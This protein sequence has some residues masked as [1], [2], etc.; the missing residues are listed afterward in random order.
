MAHNGDTSGKV[1]CEFFAGMGLVREAL[2]REGWRVAYANDIDPLKARLYEAMTGETLDQRDIHDVQVGDLPRA[3]LWTASFPCTDLSLA[4]KG[5]GI[6]GGQSGAVWRIFQLL[7]ETPEGERPR[8]LLFENVPGLLSSHAGR[9]LGALV[10]AV[11]ALGYG[12]DIVRIDAKWFTPQSRPRLFLI[13]TRLDDPLAP[14]I[15][16]PHA[17]EA[18]A[19]RHQGIIDAMRTH[20]SCPWHARPTPRPPAGEAAHLDE[21]LEDIPPDSDRWWPAERAAHFRAQIHPGHEQLAQSLIDAA[22]VRALP[23]FRRIR[24][25]GD[26]GAK[27]P[28]IELRDDA[29]AGCLRTPKGGSAK[30]MLLVA[31]NGEYRV[32]FLTPLECARLQGLDRVPEG[33]RD[34]EIL[35]GLGDAVCVPAVQ[36]ALRILEQE[37][38]MTMAVQPLL[39][40]HRQ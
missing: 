24:A 12:M 15:A 22:A 37:P 6:H 21:I 17:L 26:N 31:G 1:A 28:V 10:E 38:L 19:L 13:A 30:Q 3:D 39:A 27:R 9:D 32:R 35:F 5:A 14:P 8:W 2:V 23:G 20:E 25:V 18:T 11:N 4:G 40:A 34:N 16:D 36:W 7:E 29:L 33:F